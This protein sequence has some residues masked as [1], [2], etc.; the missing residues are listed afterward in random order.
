MASTEMD[1][2]GAVRVDNPRDSAVLVEED[3]VV[4]VGDAIG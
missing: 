3:V 4:M 2:S 1:P